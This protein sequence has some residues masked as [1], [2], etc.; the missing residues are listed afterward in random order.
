MSLL[1]AWNEHDA[2]ERFLAVVVQVLAGFAVD[3]HAAVVTEDLRRRSVGNGENGLG[4][5]I[6]HLAGGIDLLRHGIRYA[7]P[8]EERERP[9][10]VVRARDDEIVRADALDTAD[11][12]AP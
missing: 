3:P 5:Q 6:G 2:A 12:P 9:V 10:V 8:A 1:S 4:V 7:G 11:A